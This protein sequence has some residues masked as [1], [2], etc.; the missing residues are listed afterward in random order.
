M[1]IEDV[2][3]FL[4]EKG[5]VYLALR[6]FIPSE[7]DIADKACCWCCQSNVYFQVLTPTFDIKQFG[8]Q[9]LGLEDIALVSGH[10]TFRDGRH[11]YPDYK[12]LIDNEP[13]HEYYLFLKNLLLE[14]DKRFKKKFEKLQHETEHDQMYFVIKYLENLKGSIPEK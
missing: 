1:S 11:P 13:S 3:V 10:D 4:A 2:R 5:I 9:D 6:H 7:K 14:K 12:Q 8:F